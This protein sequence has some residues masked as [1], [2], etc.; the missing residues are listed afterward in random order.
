MIEKLE[1]DPHNEGLKL[2]VD[3]LEKLFNM[4]GL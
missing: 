1:K 4:I 3:E 2:T